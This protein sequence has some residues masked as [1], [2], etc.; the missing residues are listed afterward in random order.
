MNRQWVLIWLHPV[1]PALIVD[2]AQRFEKHFDH[3][4]V[5]DRT[6]GLVRIVLELHWQDNHL[7]QSLEEGNQGLKVWGYMRQDIA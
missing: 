1:N 5:C 2:V 7:S 3:F 6:A 4:V